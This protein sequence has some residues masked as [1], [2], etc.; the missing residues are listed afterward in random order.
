MND[1][2]NKAKRDCNKEQKENTKSKSRKEFSTNFNKPL[3][4]NVRHPS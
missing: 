3:N 2:T 1:A 4:S